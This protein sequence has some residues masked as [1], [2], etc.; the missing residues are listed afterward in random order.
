MEKRIYWFSGTGHAYEAARELGAD[1]GHQ[2]VRIADHP[3]GEDLR[4]IESLGIIFP[5]YA[6]GAPEM[7]ERF[8]AGS[9]FS[10]NS[11]IWAA[12][13]SGGNPGPALKVASR[14][15]R[16]GG[17]RLQ[18]GFSVRNYTPSGESKP[19]GMIRFMQKISASSPEDFA[20][21]RQRI[22]EAVSLRQKQ[23][24]ESATPAGNLFGGFFHGFALKAF[25]SQDR[26]FTATESCT[27]CGLCTRLCSAGNIELEGNKP[28]WKGGCQQCYG[29]LAACPAQAITLAQESFSSFVLNPRVRA[30]ELTL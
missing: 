2:L 27:G 15:I 12:A 3:E 11:Y 4:N 30:E 1:T 14:Q 23:R 6:W 9:R 22:A 26:L 29:C 20:A 7:V 17:G 18:A 5:I 8:L 16:K 24:I 13:V 19:T 28:V 10:K 21:R 25:P